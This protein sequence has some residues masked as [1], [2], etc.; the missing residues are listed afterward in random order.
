MIDAKEPSRIYGYHRDSRFKNNFG[1]ADVNV[2]FQHAGNKKDEYLTLSYRFSH[3]PNDHDNHTELSGVDNYYLAEDFPQWNINDASTME[4]TA[5]IDYTT[6]TWKNH[7][8]E[9]GVKY[10]N[11]QSKSETLEQIY[12]TSSESWEDVSAD[13]SRFKHTEHIYA[14]YIGYQMKFKK[15]GVKLGLRGEGT[16]L[17]ANFAKAPQMNFNADYFD[18]VPSATLAYQLDMTSQV[19]TGIMCEFNVRV[20]LI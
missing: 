10:I 4:H 5:Q 7:T 13:N 17:T 1:S 15:L 18:V 3:S 2:D 16:N 9:G 11:R 6:P 8:I 20:Y 19:R 12:R 14:A